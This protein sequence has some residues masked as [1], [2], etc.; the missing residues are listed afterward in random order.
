MQNWVV[1]WGLIYK[2][3]AYMCLIRKH[4]LHNT[5]KRIYSLALNSITTKV[6]DKVFRLNV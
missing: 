5:H 6:S 3:S 2:K 4:T 1:G